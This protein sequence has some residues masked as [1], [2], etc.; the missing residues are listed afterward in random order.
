MLSYWYWKAIAGLV[1][2]LVTANGY[3][4]EVILP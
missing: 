1:P 3:V 2:R 4:S